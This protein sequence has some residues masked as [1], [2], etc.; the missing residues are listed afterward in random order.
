MTS[1]KE[2]PIMRD[3]GIVAEALEEQGSEP[4]QE[5]ESLCMRCG[6]NGITRM[7]L[8]RIPHFREIVLMA[9]ECP[10]CSEKNNEVQFAGQLQ[11]QGCTYYLQVIQNDLKTLNRQV[12]KSDSATIKIPELDFEIPPEA[13]RGVLSTV[14]GVLSRAARELQELQE[15]RRKVDPKVAEALDSFLVKLNACARGE[16]GFTLILDD[17][18]G[19]SFIENPY[20]LAEDPMLTVQHYHRTPEQHAALGFLPETGIMTNVLP[21]ESSSEIAE[22]TDKYIPAGTRKLPH[23]AVGAE[24][25]HRAIAQGNSVELASALFKYSAPEEVM[26]FP[27]TC[28]GCQAHCDTRMYVTHIPYFKEVI[29]MASTCDTCGY[30]N[31]E[32][33]PGGSISAKGKRTTVCVKNGLDLSRDV[34]K[35]DTASVSIPEIELEL[36]PGTLGGL[37]T[38]VEG[39]IVNISE[40]LQRVHEFDIGDSA[41]PSRRKKWQNFDLELKELL[42]TEKPW[43]LVLDDA[44]DNSFIAPVTDTF[45]S[46]AQLRI[47][48]YE[49]TW[50]QNEELGLND[51][52][53][54]MADAVYDDKNKA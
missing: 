30:K 26:M 13:Q 1:I 10:H 18:S 11:P 41:D 51:M 22:E 20:G 4:L 46:D 40:S 48:E 28:A 19:N 29:V 27:S 53:T 47:E 49:R 43:T 38:T 31:S 45:E 9:F 34:I 2:D 33:K 50:E 15:E 42:K 32:L 21:L 8:T 17:P 25:A 44:L 37:I 14:E 6:E 35:S 3:L 36:A 5:I 52:D 24:A 12:V 7:L 16:Q 23:G 39:L 54:S